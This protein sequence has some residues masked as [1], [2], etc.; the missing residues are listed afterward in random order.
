[1][2]QR[3]KDG[4]DLIK[5]TATGGVLSLGR[6]R[7]TTRSS[8]TTSCKPSSRRRTTTASTVAVHAHGAEGMKR[9]IR[10]GVDSIEHGTFMT[11]RP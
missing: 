3:Y 10:A 7:P 1:M 11:T 8:P 6:K 5:L 9:A 2:R 4:A